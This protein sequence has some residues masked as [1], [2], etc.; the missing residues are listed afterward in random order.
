MYV[1][2]TSKNK[3]IKI[4][5]NK[6]IHVPQL[7]LYYVRKKKIQIVDHKFPKKFSIMGFNQTKKMKDNNIKYYIFN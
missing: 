2:N 6:E 7:V 4:S 5:P 1:N 3:Q